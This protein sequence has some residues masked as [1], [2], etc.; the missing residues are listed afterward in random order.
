MV[1]DTPPSQDAF[2]HQNLN[3]YHKEYKGYAPDILILKTR[4]EFK[5]KATVTPKLIHDTL[6][7]QDATTHQIQDP[8]LK[9]I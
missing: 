8:W 6:P 5:V 9:K 4:S 2:T 7:S 3:S 1:P